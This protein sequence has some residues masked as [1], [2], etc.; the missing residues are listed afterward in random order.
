[1]LSRRQVLRHNFS[2]RND[3]DE[4][5]RLLEAEA[6]RPCCSSIGP[7]PDKV[8]PKSV[9]DIP[10]A[11]H[12]GMGEGPQFARFI[13]TTSSKTTPQLQLSV[14][15]N[16]TPEFEIGYIGRDLKK[17]EIGEAS[18]RLFRITCRKTPEY[19]RDT[20]ATV[21]AEPPLQAIFAEDD[22]TSETKPGVVESR[23]LVKVTIPASMKSGPNSA[24]LHYKW[25]SGFSHDQLISWDVQP[26]VTVSPGA[27]IV[28]KHE[29]QREIAVIV[30]SRKTPFS[31]IT[32]DGPCLSGPATFPDYRSTKHLIKLKVSIEEKTTIRIFY[33]QDRDGSPGPENSRTQRAPHPVVGDTDDHVTRLAEV[34]RRRAGIYPDRDAC[35]DLRDEHPYSPCPARRPSGEGG[36]PSRPV[37][38]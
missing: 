34:C 22:T 27:I 12:A 31:I 14:R 15:T 20:P 37:P 23:R 18:E 32:V 35:R 3:S 29:V 30:T 11:F 24:T 21:E 5:I 8:P 9:V 13:V 2:L 10:V 17:P 33:C 19:G 7:I 6:L 28:K 26:A 4:V 16:L 25:N 38:E 1:M 36:S